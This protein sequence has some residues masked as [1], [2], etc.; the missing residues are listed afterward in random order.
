MKNRRSSSGGSGGDCEAPAKAEGAKSEGS[1][2]ED[3]PEEATYLLG[4]KVAAGPSTLAPPTQKV[5]G[6][7][8]GWF[9]DN[10]GISQLADQFGW[11]LLLMLFASQHLMKGF[12]SSFTGPCVSFLYASYKVSGPQMQIFGGVTQLPWAMKPVLGLV[13]DALP[14]QGYHKA[15]YILL[16]SGLG[17]FACAAIGIVPQS[18]LN[19]NRLVVCLFMMQLQFS[20]C[21]L[22]TEAKYAEKMRSRPEHGPAL[23]TYVWFGLNAG[24]LLA[25]AMAGPI[26]DRW[27]VRIPFM[28]ALL[29]ISFI[30]VPLMQNC[31]EE[32]PKSREQ[33]AADRAQLCKQREACILCFLM[34]IG[35][36][37]LTILGIC[38][39]SVRL[40]AFAS[41]AVALVMLVSFSVVLR[42]V[43]AKVNAFFLIQT[44]VGFSVG[45]AS[46]YFFTDGPQ[47]YPEG[48]HFSKEFFI[49]VLGV[50]SSI[51]AL[52]GVYSY[53]RFASTWTYRRLLLFSNLALCVLSMADVFVF[54]RLNVRFGIPDHLCVMGASVLQSVIGQWMWMPGVVILSQLCPQGMEA[55]MYAL[56]AGCH[57]LGNTIA[58]NCGALALELLNCQP[59]GADN[60]SAQFN[61]LWKGALASVVMPTLTLALLPWMIPDAKQTDKILDEND[62]DATEGS[63]LRR[64]RGE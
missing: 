29:P 55:T 27:G 28:I 5:A 6:S 64:W 33:A 23:M 63:L 14:I 45:G 9:F 58:S 35:T 32:R 15:P 21:D 43:I 13:S 49:S 17:I 31:L 25:T 40:N 42:P 53:Q 30:L 61:N 50:V 20:T 3:S 24:G 26:I 10:T 46:F 38:Y 22:L 12:A 4:G 54:M 39:E 59:S 56:L 34:F 62:R 36:V 51:C 18:H 8:T 16:A 1:S 60:E 48:P 19:I 57:N 7:V 11:P 2:V 41:I 47:Q 44:S 52:I 37:C